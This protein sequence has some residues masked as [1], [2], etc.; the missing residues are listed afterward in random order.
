M[1][2][3]LLQLE[4]S[5]FRKNSVI[6][7]LMVFF[8]L[9]FPLS[10]YFGSVLDKVADFF[11][12]K[13]DIL[14]APLI[15]DYLGYAG[16]WI[17]FFFL[18]VMVIYTVTV[19]VTNKTM[20][21]NII[22]GMSRTEYYLAKVSVILVLAT[23]ATLYYFLLAVIIG[24]LNTDGSSISEILKNDLAV[25]RFWLMSFAY[26]NFALLIAFVIRKAGVAVFIYLTYILMG[27]PLIKI[28]LQK[29]LSESTV[30]NYLPMNSVEDLMPAPVFKMAE[31]LTT[32]GS[33]VLLG[34][35]QAA[36]ATTIYAVIFIF[37]SY[38]FFLSKDM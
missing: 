30:M 14:A 18:G 38:R 24:G 17:V 35:G 10:L 1:I 15:W 4:W 2:I 21:Q 9:F 33:E 22:T 26:M 12:M 20:R 29:Y 11:P 7:L 13:V 5:K 8:L 25:P 16:N 23:V 32:D 34:H 27:E 31:N 6:S 3:K 19:D 36:I 28:W 37:L